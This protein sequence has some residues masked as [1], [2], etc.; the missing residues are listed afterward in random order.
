M[1]RDRHRGHRLSFG[2]SSSD[3]PSLSRPTI[4]WMPPVPPDKRTDNDP[5]SRP[6]LRF[7]VSAWAR[8]M[9]L[10]HAGP[11]EIGGFG[12]SS[13]DDPLRVREIATVR[14]SVSAASVRFDD[15]AVADYFEDQAA[16]GRTPS[17][18]ARIWVHTHPGDCPHPSGTDELTFHTAFGGC[19]WAVMF[20]LARGGR[21]YAR[22]RYGIGPG[23][24]I[25]LPVAIDMSAVLNDADLDRCRQEY[26]ANIHR[27]SSACLSIPMSS[28]SASSSRS[29]EFDEWEA[30]LAAEGLGIDPR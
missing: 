24:Q 29:V 19:D 25:R 30:L 21:V 7:S 26:Q 16:A 12:I 3:R 23:G 28:S 14:Q 18:F 1:N 20:I 8:L 13:P 4:T 22:L 9:V 11:T 15:V 10:C 6:I 2:R 17:Q 5:T 27:E